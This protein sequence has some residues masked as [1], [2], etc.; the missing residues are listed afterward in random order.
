MRNVN[1]KFK[2]ATNRNI[3]YA[4]SLTAAKNFCKKHDFIV[5][6]FYGH[7]PTTEEKKAAIRCGWGVY[8][9]PDNN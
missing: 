3:Y 2:V 5:L 8:C 7:I 6:H 9:I 1:I 4:T